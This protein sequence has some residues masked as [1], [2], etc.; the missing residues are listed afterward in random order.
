[1]AKLTLQNLSSLQ[2]EQSAINIIN[3]NNDAIEAA[4]EKTLSRDNTQPNQMTVELDMNGQQILNLPAPAT[5][6]SPA[7]LQ[8]VVDPDVVLNV[9]PVGTSGATVPLLNTNVTFSGNNTHTGTET[10]SNSVTAT[11]T[12]TVSGQNKATFIQ[13]DQNGYAIRLQNISAT[14]TTKHIRVSPTGSLDVV[15]SNFTAVSATITDGGSISI[16]G[17]YLGDGT[18]LT[19]VETS[20]HA[21]ATYSPI[22]RQFNTQTGTSYTL[23]LTDA[24]R[25]VLT[26]NSSPVTITIPPNSSVAFPILT[27]IDFLQ[28]GGGK[29]T[30]AQGS[31]VTI[32]SNL[33]MKSIAGQY[34]TATI[35][36]IS[37]DAWVMFGSL[38]A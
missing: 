24:G 21:S 22:T 30:L 10:F 31:G 37:T 12:V 34:Q 20:A 17:Q 28:F 23:A 15:N 7:R 19:G 27:Q 5:I 6:N 29:L 2:N 11:G 35:L 9:P 36:K 1:M 25:V 33:S 3:N 8:D 18:A 38:S 16:P 4:V 14:P 13:P 32:S 26:T